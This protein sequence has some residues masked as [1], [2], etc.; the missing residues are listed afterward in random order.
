MS[1]VKLISQ[2]MEYKSLA[3]TF[4]HMTKTTKQKKLKAAYESEYRMC[5]VIS[6]LLDSLI[7][8]RKTI[9]KEGSL[10]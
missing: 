8:I 6:E 4:K 10:K 5:V 9:E 1:V 3:K 2:Q 7:E